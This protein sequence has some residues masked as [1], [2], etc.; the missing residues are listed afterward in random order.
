MVNNVTVLTTIEGKDLIKYY[1]NATQYSATFFDG[2]GNVLANREI[3]FNIIGKTYN[4]MTDEMVQLH[5]LLT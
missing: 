4:M 5:Y 3:T 2:Q 1:K